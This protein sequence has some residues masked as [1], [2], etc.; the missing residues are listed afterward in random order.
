[1]PPVTYLHPRK[2]IIKWIFNYV[3]IYAK[4]SWLPYLCPSIT[5]GWL[6]H[7]LYIHFNLISDQWAMDVLTLLVWSILTVQKMWVATGM[8]MAVW[9]A[10]RKFKSTEIPP[11][12]HVVDACA[13][14]NTIKAIYPM[15]IAI[16]NID[17]IPAILCHSCHKDWYRIYHPSCTSTVTGKC[18]GNCAL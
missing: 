8:Y 5:S 12:A 7:C 17:E 4:Q 6:H 13:C 15:Y 11:I 18:T 2:S 3:C 1:M 14:W 16:G 10:C 9:P